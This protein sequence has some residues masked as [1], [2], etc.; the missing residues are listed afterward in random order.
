MASPTPPLTAAQAQEKVKMEAVARAKAAIAAVE[1]LTGLKAP[2]N[3]IPGFRSPTASEGGVSPRAQQREAGRKSMAGN[4]YASPTG[5]GDRFSSPESNGTA[6]RPSSE[7]DTRGSV[8]SN[9]GSAT[10]RWSIAGS[11]SPDPT[12]ALSQISGLKSAAAYAN[13][14]ANAGRT[15]AV[16]GSAAAVPGAGTKESVERAKQIASERKEEALAALEAAK[17]AAAREDEEW[18]KKVAKVRAFLLFFFPSCWVFS[19]PFLNFR[20]AL[21]GWRELGQNDVLF[22]FDGVT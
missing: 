17:A 20:G 15:G 13:G 14:V 6:V 10:A 8:N 19:G 3:A 2:A 7:R 22:A 21:L 11:G 1:K 18:K 12:V 16:P 9:G 4:G 5:G